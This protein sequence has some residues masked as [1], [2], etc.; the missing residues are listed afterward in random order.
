[1]SSALSGAGRL[2]KKRSLVVVISDFYS[3]NWKDEMAGLC[4]KHDV[5]AIRI[6][7]PPEIPFPGLI[8]LEDPETGV[9]IEAPAGL[10]SFNQSWKTWRD[11]RSLQ[12]ES[13]CRRS[14]ASILEL[15]TDADAPSA[16]I[17]FFGSR[18]QNKNRASKERIFRNRLQ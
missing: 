9:R 11:E 2:L 15:S 3:V 18:S 8:T 17:K 13:E 1:M 6:S 12:W 7:D 4:R 14:G 16:L 5:I 10:E